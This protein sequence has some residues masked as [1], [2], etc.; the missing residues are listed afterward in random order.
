MTAAEFDSAPAAQWVE[1]YRYELI[2]GVLV[3]AP[4]PDSSERGPNDELGMQ[5]RVYQRTNP[6][7]SSLNDTLPEQTLNTTPN[8]RR[9]DRAVWAGLDR[10]PNPDLDTPSIVIEFV[11]E[12]RRDVV[13]DY[14][15]KRD[16][17]RQLGVIEYWVIDRFRRQ[18]VVYRFRADRAPG[19]ESIIHETAIYRTDLL[20]GFELRLADLFKVADLYPSAKRRRPP[21]GGRPK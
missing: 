4:P 20:P 10:A 19:E 6:R 14:E 16:E 8:R 9:C 18:M 2:N 5:L 3:V 7:G 17:Y 11:S 21:A 1:G 12:S 13:R 15:I